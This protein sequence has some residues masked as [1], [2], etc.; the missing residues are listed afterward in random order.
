MAGVALFIASAFTPLPNILT[1]WLST[2][3][4]LER[5]EAIIVLAGGLQPDGMLSSGSLRRALHGMD[6]YRAGLASLLVLLGE[7]RGGGPTEAEVRAELA[8]HLG[9]SP[10]VILTEAGARTTREE[11][12]RAE[13]LLRP[14]GVRRILLVTDS[15]HMARA[16]GVFERAGFEVLS[17]PADDLSNRESKP[18]KRLQLMRRILEELLGR[19]YYR[20][21][22][23]L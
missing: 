7:A 19:L 11:A 2:P 23:Y 5:A 17:A 18:E 6:L 12:V 22:G 10:K 15:L 3:P 14:I 21:G 9:I 8:G 16:R 1:G 20:V 4:R 13:T